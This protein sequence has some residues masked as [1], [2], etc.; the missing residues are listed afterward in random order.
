MAQMLRF[1]FRICYLTDAY[2]WK[3]SMLA[4]QCLR[5]AVSKMAVDNRLDNRVDSAYCI[6]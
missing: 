6:T 4:C 5:E 3:A 1:R 2:S